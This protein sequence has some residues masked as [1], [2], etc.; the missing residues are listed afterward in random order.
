MDFDPKMNGAEALTIM[1]NAYAACEAMSRLVA[2]GEPKAAR[3]GAKRLWKLILEDKEK[4]PARHAA[5]IVIDQF[6]EHDGDMSVAV[7]EMRNDLFDKLPIE[8]VMLKGRL[9][10]KLESMTAQY[11]ARMRD[12][13]A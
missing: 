4:G 5:E 12:W 10:A 3:V 13:S 7:K 2:S 11:L 6:F 1:A 9:D 8:S